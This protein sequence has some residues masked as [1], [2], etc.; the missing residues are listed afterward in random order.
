MQF[1][2]NTAAIEDDARETVRFLLVHRRFCCIVS[3]IRDNSR[4][5]QQPLTPTPRRRSR[6]ELCSV[7]I[8]GLS[9]ISGISESGSHQSNN[10]LQCSVIEFFTRL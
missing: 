8:V 4:Q 1:I 9:R 7:W 3:I 6:R 5:A 10:M 2:D